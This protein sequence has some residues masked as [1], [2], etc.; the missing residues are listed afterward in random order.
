MDPINE[1][2]RA[3]GLAVVED[4][5]CAIGT[6]YQGKACGSLGTMGCFSFHPR[7]VITT[8]EGG[9]IT[10]DQEGLADRIRPLRTHGGVRREGRFVFESAGYN[11]R[12]SDLQAAVGVAQ[13]RKLDALISG[14]RLLAAQMNR[15]LGEVA[16]CTL[17]VEPRWGGHIYQS[18]VV[19][20]A[21][22]IDRD[23]VI[24]GMKEQG[25]ET[26]LGTYALH[27]EPFFAKTYGYRPGDVP[28]AYRA[29]RSTLTLPLYPP[30]DEGDLERIAQALRRALG[31]ADP[32]T[33]R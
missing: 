11:Y 27:S 26:T 21:P 30:M 7:K 4:A 20:L 25:V 29:A 24:Q 19:L 28:H 14:K 16:G 10:T 18:Y 31:G 6:T 15:L 23:L 17:P 8:G 22:E 9:M 5:A 32:G 12:M 33:K 1:L 2:A 3:H 13:I